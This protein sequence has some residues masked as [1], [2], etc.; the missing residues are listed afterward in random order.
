MIRAFLDSRCSQPEYLD[1]MRMDTAALADYFRFIEF[2]NRAGGGHAA[3][4]AGLGQI[5]DSWPPGKIMNLVDIGCGTGDVC[6]AILSWAQKNTLNI[7][8]TG[9]DNNPR[10]IQTARS[11]VTD[12][13]TRFITG[14]IF[15]P[16]PRADVVTVSMLLHH[17][18]DSEAFT[19]LAR[20]VHAARHA[21]IITEL[22]RS[23]KAYIV[24]W[25]ATRLTGNPLSRHD[26]LLSIRKGFTI[27]ELTGFIRRGRW[28]GVVKKN[29]MGRLIAV[30][31]RRRTEKLYPR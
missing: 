21:V 11:A 29:G 4:L 30:V 9:I 13:R 18:P 17:F 16:L 19:A 24:C 8:Y 28:S 14:S 1:T 15:G 3:L 2:T 12:P 31:S 25:I 7:R 27:E 23:L 5:G 26:A 20:A 22:E 10:I 6:R